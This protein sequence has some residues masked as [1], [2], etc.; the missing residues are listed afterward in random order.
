MLVQ[1]GTVGRTKFRAVRQ[2]V[3]VEVNKEHR[4]LHIRNK[5]RTIN[6]TREITD[7]DREVLGYIMKGYFEADV[8]DAGWVTLRSVAPRPKGW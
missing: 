1:E 5:Y 8:N 2:I 7:E 4:T 3:K 6:H